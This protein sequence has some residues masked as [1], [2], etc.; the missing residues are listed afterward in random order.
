MKLS[1]AL[2][3]NDV[4]SAVINIGKNNGFV[5]AYLDFQ[6][7][8]TVIIYNAEGDIVHSYDTPWVRKKAVYTAQKFEPTYDEVGEDGEVVAPSM[9]R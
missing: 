4:Q 1:V 3:D 7:D 2:L 6:G 9:W 8:L 5:E